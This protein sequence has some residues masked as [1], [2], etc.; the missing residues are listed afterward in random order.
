MEATTIRDLYI[1]RVREQE[2]KFA[3]KE[4]N[5]IRQERQEEARMRQEE[6]RMRQEE[7]RM[8][9]EAEKKMVAAIINCSKQGLSAEQIADL[10]LQPLDVINDVIKNNA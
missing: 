10:L 4:I 9:Q 7:A 3:Q 8:R 5:N 1:K 2:Q 6:A